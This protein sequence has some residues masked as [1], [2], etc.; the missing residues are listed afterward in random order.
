[1]ITSLPTADHVEDKWIRLS[2]FNTHKNLPTAEIYL[3]VS[4]IVSVL[5]TLPAEREYRAS[6]IGHSRIEKRV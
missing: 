5:D 2:Y 3:V 6:I 1:M 4:L